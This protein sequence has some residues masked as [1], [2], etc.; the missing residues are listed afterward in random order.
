MHK[1]VKLVVLLNR[2]GVAIRSELRRNRLGRLGL[3]SERL[4]VS[5]LCGHGWVKINR[6]LALTGLRR[7]RWALRTADADEPIPRRLILELDLLA[8]LKSLKCCTSSRIAR[9]PAIGAEMHES[10]LEPTQRNDVNTLNITEIGLDHVL[11]NAPPSDVVKHPRDANANALCRVAISLEV[12]L[13][14]LRSLRRHNWFCDLSVNVL[15]AY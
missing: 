3:S 15:F 12:R 10:A 4:V 11:L 1:Q 6:G 8:L 14:L 2:G 9:I 13:L 7:L 5:L